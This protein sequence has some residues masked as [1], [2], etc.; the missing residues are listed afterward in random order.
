MFDRLGFFIAS[1]RRWVAVDGSSINDSEDPG[2]GHDCLVLGKSQT[3]GTES[4]C[5]IRMTNKITYVDHY[6]VIID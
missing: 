2:S 1:I 3:W 4:E 5:R 6:M